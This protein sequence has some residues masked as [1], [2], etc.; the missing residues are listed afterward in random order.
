MLKVLNTLNTNLVFK[1]YFT[2]FDIKGRLFV[3]VVRAEIMH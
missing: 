2:R 1:D 3:S